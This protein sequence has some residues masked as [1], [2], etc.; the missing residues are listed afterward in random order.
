[1]IRMACLALLALASCSRKPE[2]MP[3]PP[4]AAPPA[5]SPAPAF[6]PPGPPLPPASAPLAKPQP[7]APVPQRQVPV[8]DPET[9]SVLFLANERG[10]LDLPAGWPLILRALVSAGE[11][12]SLTLQGTG[13]SWIRLL[14]VEGVDWPLASAFEATPSITIERSGRAV[15]VWTLSAD[16]TRA[17]P[18]GSY[19]L[20][21]VL[22]TSEGTSS[23]RGSVRSE[24]LRIKI[25]DPLRATPASEVERQL[26]MAHR[27][28]WIGE[29]EQALASVDAILAKQPNSA[30]ALAFKADLLAAQGRKVEAI[31][32]YNRSIA[33]LARAPSR[34]KEPP[35]DLIR[36]RD[37]LM[38]PR[39]R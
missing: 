34:V 36:R 25:V 35:V 37:A 9:P 33:S 32:L 14:R 24:P 26:L 19:A 23:W 21:A 2:G 10:S 12:R 4:P 20:T 27:A 15:A 5:S 3:V 16:Q 8:R 28:L 30:S 17:L 6:A 1:M 11:G 13:A 31:E 22:D 18:K 7:P 39:D 38:D 29:N